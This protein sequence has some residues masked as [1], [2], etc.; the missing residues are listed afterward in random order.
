MGFFRNI[1]VRRPELKVKENCFQTQDMENL[2]EGVYKTIKFYE[3]DLKNSNKWLSDFV[4]V[5]K[6]NNLDKSEVFK[7]FAL[8]MVFQGGDPRTYEP[9]KRSHLFYPE[10]IESK[11]A[12]TKCEALKSS[13]LLETTCIYSKKEREKIYHKDRKRKPS[14]ICYKYDMTGSCPVKE[15]GYDIHH[16][17]SSA[18]SKGIVSAHLVAKERWDGNINNVYFQALS[19]GGN[20]GK[21][22]RHIVYELEHVYNVN[23]KI[24]NLFCRW[25]S[26]PDIVPFV[27]AW[28]RKVDWKLFVTIDKYLIRT[29]NRMGVAPKNADDYAY[30]YAIREIANQISLKEFGFQKHNPLIIETT[31]RMLSKKADGVTQKKDGFCLDEPKCGECPATNGCKKDI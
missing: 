14:H 13:K 1:F 29:L 31:L 28:Q 22:A 18:I 19:C 3:P 20:T 10:E 21:I 12:K 4:D 17:K 27:N 25:M 11:L 23:E 16:M 15:L 30:I 8:T 7:F 2:V 24:A 9:L 6:I 26:N 5:Y